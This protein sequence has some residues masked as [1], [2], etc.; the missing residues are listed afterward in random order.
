MVKW[1]LEACI[2]ECDNWRSASQEVLWLSLQLLMHQALVLCFILLQN[3]ILTSVWAKLVTVPQW[4]CHKPKLYGFAMYVLFCSMFPKVRNHGFV[5]DEMLGRLI[6]QN[7]C[8]L[9]ALNNG[10]TFANLSELLRALLSARCKY[11]LH[12]KKSVFVITAD[13]TRLW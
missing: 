6:I 3:W 2:T 1:Q 11:R 7:V 10:R 8:S 5:N 9:I 4:N 13:T 12:S